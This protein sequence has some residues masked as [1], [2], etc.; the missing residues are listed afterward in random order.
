[1][2]ACKTSPRM[3]GTISSRLKELSQELPSDESSETD[4]DEEAELLTEDMDRQ[5]LA[6]LARCRVQNLTRKFIPACIIHEYTGVR[7][8]YT[9]A[10]T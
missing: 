4:E 5:I 6:T 1:M 7:A 9:H 10:F 3:D 8:V 2:R